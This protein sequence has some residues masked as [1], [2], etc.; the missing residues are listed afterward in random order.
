[1]TYVTVALFCAACTVAATS[2]AQDDAG[3]RPIAPAP[4][5]VNPA[6]TADLKDPIELCRNLAGTEREIC[7]RQSLERRGALPAPASGKPGAEAD[8]RRVPPR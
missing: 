8:Q 2:H 7:I 4:P 6:A 3:R 5:L 1:M